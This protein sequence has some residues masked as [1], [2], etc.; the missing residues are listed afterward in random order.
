M[1]RSWDRPR[2][3]CQGGHLPMPQTVSRA[4][5]SLKRGTCPSRSH[6]PLLTHLVGTDTRP[7]S[8]AP[9]HSCVGVEKPRGFAPVPPET[10]A[11]PPHTSPALREDSGGGQWE[12]CRRKEGFS[13]HQH[14]FTC[15][16]TEKW[17]SPVTYPCLRVLH[18]TAPFPASPSALL[19]GYSRC[20]EGETAPA[21][22]AE[23]G[24]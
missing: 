22:V 21:V 14:Y 13:Y 3:G 1:A 12:G 2:V 11:V 6:L 17:F 9:F 23:G 16:I 18:Q 24:W 10:K 20:W 15:P 5:T 4:P 7:C 19:L 8:H